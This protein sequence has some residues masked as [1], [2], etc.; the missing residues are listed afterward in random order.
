[1]S[2]DEI[3]KILIGDISTLLFFAHSGRMI[4]ILP[5]AHFLFII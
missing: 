1:M 5:L 2:K 4:E 3:S